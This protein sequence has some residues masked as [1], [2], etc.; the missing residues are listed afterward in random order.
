MTQ[1]AGRYGGVDQ[2]GNQPP[3]TKQTHVCCAVYQPCVEQQGGLQSGRMR[4]QPRI[5]HAQKTE[6]ESTA[7]RH[8]VIDEGGVSAV[9]SRAKT[10]V[11]THHLRYISRCHTTAPG[12]FQDEHEG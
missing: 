8:H 4:A 6:R 5:N 9:M 1:N 2:S 12:K 3:A 7:G 11:T 10:Q